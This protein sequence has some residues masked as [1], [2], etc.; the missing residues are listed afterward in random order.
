MCIY[1]I[2]CWSTWV[3]QTYIYYHVILI[4]NYC[5][6]YCFFKK[7]YYFYI[8]SCNTFTKLSFSYVYYFFFSDYRYPYYLNGLI[9]YRN[10]RKIEVY[11]R[12]FGGRQLRGPPPPTNI[13]I[14]TRWYFTKCMHNYH[15]LLTTAV[16]SLTDVPVRSNL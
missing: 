9:Q 11:R 4:L 8:L 2:Y 1:K 16:N 7:N 14:Y 13:Y 10:K 15:R 6:K 12:H 3:L 5:Q